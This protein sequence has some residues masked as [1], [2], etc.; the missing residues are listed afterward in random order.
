MSSCGEVSHVTAKRPRNQGVSH[1]VERKALP[2]GSASNCSGP[3]RVSRHRGIGRYSQNLVAT[4]LARDPVNSYVLY[5]QD[6]LPTDQIPT[7]P[8]AVVR[9]LRPDPDRGET[10]MAH[11]MERLAESNPDRLDVLLLLNPLELAPGYDL[12]A[13]PVSGLKM[14]AVVYDLIPLIFQEMY[15]TDW[16]GPMACDRYLQGLYRLRSYDALL[17][18]SEATRRDIRLVAGRVSGP[19]RDHRHGQRRRLLRARPH[20][21][22]AGR[23]TIA[24]ARAGDHEAVRLLRGRQGLPEEHRGG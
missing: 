20:R 22:D 17:A 6:G 14:V 7:A 18:I 9:L 19:G 1:W 8:N 21:S 23:V 2:C 10:T 4:L 11:A 16:R 5:G 24:A 12:P 3:R 15:F 13:K